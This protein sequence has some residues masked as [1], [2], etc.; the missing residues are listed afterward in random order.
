MSEYKV[1]DPVRVVNVK[2]GRY[3]KSGTVVDIDESFVLPIMVSIGGIGTR[4]ATEELELIDTPTPDP[5]AHPPHYT[6]GVPAGVEV[7]DIIRAHEAAGGTWETLNA[8]KYILRH[9]LKDN[10]VQDIKKAIQYLSMWVERQE[11]V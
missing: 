7:I 4:Y 11:T 3:G 9:T 8:V 1:G 10:P 2:D 6:E 5:V